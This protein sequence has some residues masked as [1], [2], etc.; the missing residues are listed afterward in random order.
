MLLHFFIDK[1]AEGYS[2]KLEVFDYASNLPVEE[3]SGIVTSALPSAL[4]IKC[5]GQKSEQVPSSAYNRS[6]KFENGMEIIVSR[7]GGT[8]IRVIP[9]EKAE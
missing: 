4:Y 3:V 1:I 7:K 8:I 9:K 2:R 5:E 6:F